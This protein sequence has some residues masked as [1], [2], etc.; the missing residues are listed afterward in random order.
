[1]G[2]KISWFNISSQDREEWEEFCPTNEYRIYDPETFQI[3][4]PGLFSDELVQ[5][6]AEVFVMASGSDRGIAYYMANVMRIHEKDY[7]IDQEPFG[8]A[9][10][11]PQA[12]PSGC[13]LH[14]GDW[15]GRT[16][17]YPPADFYDRVLNSG[18]GLHYPVVELPVKPSG[19]IHELEVESQHEAFNKVVFKIKEA[20]EKQD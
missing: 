17:T 8:L 18:L 20:F 15:P 12:Y 1:M 14:H 5:K 9:F 19:S 3:R 6:S 11:G 13:L 10:V 7:A 4:F 2:K 16:T